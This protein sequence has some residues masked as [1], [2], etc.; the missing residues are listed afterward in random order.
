MKKKFISMMSLLLIVMMFITACGKATDKDLQ[1]AGGGGDNKV[2]RT[3]L[4]L[5]AIGEPKTLDP[6]QVSDLVAFYV[7]HQIYNHLIDNRTD[8]NLV[9]GLAESWTYSDDGTEI[10]FKLREGVKFHNG[11]V[12]TADDVVYS[13]ETAIA[14]AFTQGVTSVMESMK[15]VDENTV[16]L[17]LKHS[18]GPIEYCVASSQIPILNKKVHEANPDGYGRNPIGTG[19]Y[20]FVEWRSGDSITLT[21]FE[22]YYK[23]AAEIK[24]VTFK[25]ITDGSTAVVALENGEIDIIDTPPRTDRQ[26]LI[27]NPNIE[28]Y[29]TEIAATVFIAINH[30]SEIGKNKKLREAIAHAIDKESLIIGSVEGIGTALE[31][32]MAKSTFGWP[33]DFKNREYNVEKAKQLLIEAGYPNGLDI[34]LK[35]NESATYFKPTEVLQDQLRQ[36]GINA[37]ISKMERGAFWDDILTK[38]DYEIVVSAATTAYPDADY[39]YSTFHGKMVTE[40]RNYFNYANPKLDELLERG[41]LSND[42]EERKQIYRD[43]C[44]LFKEDVVS[45]PLY[46]YMTPIAANKDLQGVMAHPTNRMF[47][48]DYS[49]K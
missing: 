16:T 29:E 17:I 2:K 37:S 23:G 14:S 42:Q 38:R 26:N 35:T 8:G 5:G 7:T 27:N 13:F 25:I 36:I 32:P 40:G 1:P 10:T 15:K 3:D 4:N 24:D 11:D 41:R 33:A 45:I 31:T 39:I 43:I 28:Y 6:T 19:P 49:W 20:K 21:A 44:E 47:V 30:H 18:Y 46:T 22:D 9:P 48:Y 12:M 34:T